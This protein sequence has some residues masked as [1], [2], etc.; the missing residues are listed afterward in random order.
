M[1]TN[2][3]VSF[4]N[5]NIHIASIY[6]HHD[7]YIHGRADC[8]GNNLIQFLANIKLVDSMERGAILFQYANGI[9]DLA[10]QYL[11][12]NKNNIGYVYLTTK[13][14]ITDYTYIVYNIG[15]QIYLRL[16]EHNIDVT[17]EEA[18]KLLKKF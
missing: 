17:I 3:K 6:H 11:L 12:K 14:H 15:L 2:A 1:S 4:Y 8:V 10:A 16:E 7:G 18:V 5:H 9:G 13:D